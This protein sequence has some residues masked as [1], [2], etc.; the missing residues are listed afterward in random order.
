M[1]GSWVSSGRLLFVLGV[2]D[3]SQDA[4]CDET[5]R[6]DHS[7]GTRQLANLDR[8]ARAA[9]L[10]A[11]SGAGGF[12]HVLTGGAAAGVHQ[13]LD[14]IS[15]CHTPSLFPIRSNSCVIREWPSPRRR[16]TASSS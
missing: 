7:S 3:H 12:D 9:H 16:P 4:W 2:L 14:E 13:N 5:G 15:L 11:A 6:A 10:D 8:R 1:V